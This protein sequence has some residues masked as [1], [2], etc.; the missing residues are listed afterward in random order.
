MTSEVLLAE[1]RG[2]CAG[3]DRAID[4]VEHALTKFGRP[5]Y[6]RHEIV[7]NTYVVDDLKKKG[8]IFIEELSDVPPGAT[9][10][11]S[12]HGVSRA[13]Q[14]EAVQRGFRIFDATCPLV[15]K[16]HV[17][18][19][20]LHKEGYEFI[21]IGHKGHPEVEGTM[22]QLDSG[23]HLVEDVEDVAKVQPAQTELLAVVTQTTLS[24]DDAAEIVAAVRARFPQVREPKQQDICYATQN[25]Q[26]A[27]KL[28][29]PMVDVVIVVG[30]PT[31]SNSNR[32]RELADR[33][34]TPAYMVDSAADLDATWFEGAQKVGL[35]AGASAPDV[36]V[37]DVIQR[38]RAMGA[39]SVRTLDGIQET[40]KFPLPKGF[41]MDNPESPEAGSL[42]SPHA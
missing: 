19:A 8:A 32:L 4:I 27:V 25:R 6:V 28:M 30:S 31:S 24:V 21:M 16:V 42:Q 2:F 36:L 26:D 11:F 17:E 23:I 29:S 10:I 37:Q 15:S 3:V 35:T 39:V 13:I 22:G 7:H 33:L 34:G 5:I 38:L 20:K 41:K 14:D 40:I 1:P 18:L 12:A 9:L